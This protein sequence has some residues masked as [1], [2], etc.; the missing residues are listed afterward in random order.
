MGGEQTSPQ[1]GNY[2]ANEP[3]KRRREK[4]QLTHP[5]WKGSW[6]GS[7]KGAERKSHQVGQVEMWERR[8][9]IFSISRVLKMDL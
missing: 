6:K 5:V 2:W 7:W 9:T 3:E 8:V 1:F 4:G